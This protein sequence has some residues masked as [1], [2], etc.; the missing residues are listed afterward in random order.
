MG[1]AAERSEQ[2]A[3][4][5]SPVRRSIVPEAGDD[6]AAIARRALPHLPEAEGVQALQSWNL[7]LFLRAPA[8]PGS[9]RAGNPIL[10]SD[11]VFVEPPLAP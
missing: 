5:L 6:W 9:P 2:R 4:G 8:P 7:H 11:I 3:S 1:A 10:P